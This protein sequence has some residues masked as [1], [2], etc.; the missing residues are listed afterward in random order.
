V[1]LRTQD[2]NDTF[3]LKL[4]DAEPVLLVALRVFSS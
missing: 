3:V 4:G 1:E 2:Q